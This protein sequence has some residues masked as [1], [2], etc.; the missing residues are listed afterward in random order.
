LKKLLHILFFFITISCYTQIIQLKIEGSTEYENKIIDSINY[1]KKHSNLKS[2]LNETTN[3]SN[4]LLKKGFLD[5]KIIESKKLND[6]IYIHQ[7]SLG[8]RTKYIHIYIYIYR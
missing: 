4:T 3:T 5:L 6:T 2:L 8:T 7:I 1:N